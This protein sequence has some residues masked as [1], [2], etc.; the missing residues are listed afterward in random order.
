MLSWI[1]NGNKVMSR[2]PKGRVN[3]GLAI[4]RFVKDSSRGFESFE[5]TREKCVDLLM[6]LQGFYWWQMIQLLALAVSLCATLVVNIKITKNDNFGWKILRGKR[7][8]YRQQ[9]IL[10]DNPENVRCSLF[11]IGKSCTR[12]AIPGICADAATQAEEMRSS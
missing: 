9:M 1:Q 2:T 7:D 11:M 5:K 6:R 4:L 8:R 10:L 12:D 3:R